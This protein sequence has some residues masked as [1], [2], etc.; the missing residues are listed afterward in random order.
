M[1]SAR[2]STR[3]RSTSAEG[4][5]SPNLSAAWWWARRCG[6]GCR[7]SCCWCRCWCWLGR[8][9]R[10][11]RRARASWPRT[12]VSCA[13]S[14]SRWPQ[15]PADCTPSRSS[16]ACRSPRRPST[17][18]ASCRRWRPAPGKVSG[19]PTGRPPPARRAGRRRPARRRAAPTGTS[20]RRRG[21]T[22]TRTASI[23]TFSSPPW[24]R[25]SI[26]I[27]FDSYIYPT[28]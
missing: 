28:I 5:T 20:R 19:W 22:T 25:L 9:R 23:S 10:R 13:A 27:T 15:V 26:P 21:C 4:G 2:R 18:C 16:W 3:W 14:S 17:D 11:R 24:V 1:E 7:C 8:R 12:T 6:R